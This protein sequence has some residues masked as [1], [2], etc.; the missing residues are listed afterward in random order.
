MIFEYIVIATIVI[1]AIIGFKRGIASVILNIFGFIASV[2]LSVTFAEPLS[3]LIYSS[4]IKPA[5]LENIEQLIESNG[6]EGA[7]DNYLLALPRWVN[8][9]ISPLYGIFGYEP[10]KQLNSGN[11]LEASAYEVTN[12]I[13][14]FVGQAVIDTFSFLLQ[15]I[16]FFIVFLIFKTI[17]KHF[18]VIFKIP[19]IAQ[20]NALFGAVLGAVEGFIIAFIVTNLFEMFVISANPTFLE[21]I[22]LLSSG[23][24]DLFCNTL[25]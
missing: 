15:I 14:R 8:N 17:L 9:I 10:N 21:D 6:I 18:L 23:F 12:L 4:A 20:L 3:K 16:L 11:F 24:F 13:E 19:I 2:F 25:I 7:L 22:I 1:F 5:F